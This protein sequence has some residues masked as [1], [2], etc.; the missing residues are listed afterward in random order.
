MDLAKYLFT[1]LGQIGVRSVHGVPSDYNLRALDY[2]KSCN[3]HWVGN[4]NELC[5]GYAADGYA[6][7]KGVG[8]LI[9]SF[10]PGELSAI[11]A[12]AGA[13]SE[14][15]PVVHIV[16]TPPLKAQRAGACLHHSLGDGN[17]GV[18]ADMFK[19]I[20]A[21]KVNLIDAATAPQM[22]DSALRECILK[23]QPVYISLPTDM[24]SAQVPAPEH[25]IDLSPPIY[26]ASSESA[27]VDQVFSRIES[28][29]R[30][31]ILVDGFTA[32]YGVLDELDQLVRATGF[33]TLTTPF[34]KSI[35]DETIRNFCGVYLG[36]AGDLALQSWIHDCDLV[37]YFG[38]EPSDGNT[39]GFSAVPNPDVTITFEGNS[40][41]IGAVETPCS[42][43]S[44]LTKLLAR[45]DKSSIT[46]KEGY[47]H[48]PSE[49]PRA[50]D[51]DR[52][53]DHASFWPY[54]SR[55]I[56]SEDV[57]LTEPGTA[58][59][60]SPALT[61]PPSTKLINSSR[62]LSIGHMLAASQG[63]ALAQRDIA[64]VD[65]RPPGR[66]ILFE[67]DGSLQM[68]AQAISDIIRNKLDVIIFLLNNN[69]YTTERVIHGFSESYNDI[70]P[71]RNLQAANYFGADLDD[72]SYAVRTFSAAN[73]GE[74][75]DALNHAGLQAGNGLNIV[76][77]A[78]DMG[79]VPEALQRLAHYVSKRNSGDK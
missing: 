16:G 25:P 78:M 38:P 6:R 40:T 46:T 23:S 20:T 39:F 57:L 5:S 50:V 58:T 49:A 63:A 28:C 69:G 34:G 65:G 11:N 15:I 8:A 72:A 75:Q 13:Y 41:R 32:R 70:Q 42:V 19:N 74:L 60:G 17:F 77:I 76:E 79:D 12:I 10:G 26:E 56:R 31:L 73:W 71:W 35:V 54:I 22:I 36:S 21:A 29:R 37:L 62:W 30:P 7:V 53:I 24:V 59:Y 48:R 9:S 27:V 51:R 1:R 18:F 45:L 2:L 61:L 66:T 64:E 14:K 52:I 67:G 4:A 68:T 44:I 33:T 47:Q 43:K 3:L 55:F